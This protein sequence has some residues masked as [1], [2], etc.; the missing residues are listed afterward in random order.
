M[1]TITSLA[2]LLRSIRGLRLVSVAST[3]PTILAKSCGNGNAGRKPSNRLLTR[4]SCSRHQ[5]RDQPHHHNR[6]AQNREPIAK[7]RVNGPL[8]DIAE[9]GIGRTLDV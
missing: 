6:G 1:T 4:A 8:R 2:V 7:S 5:F 3:T 9:S